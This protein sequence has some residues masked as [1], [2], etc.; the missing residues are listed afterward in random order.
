[1]RYEVNLCSHICQSYNKV[2]V[3]KL[4]KSHSWYCLWLAMK[5][6]WPSLVGRIQKLSV[7][8]LAL[9]PG[10]CFS[11][12]GLQHVVVV[13]S[14]TQY[15]HK[16]KKMIVYRCYHCRY[17]HIFW[18]YEERCA[19]PDTVSG[20]DTKFIFFYREVSECDLTLQIHLPIHLRGRRKWDPTR[21]RV[22]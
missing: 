7:P 3:S 20:S 19:D 22:F 21:R 16:L 8:H 12:H 14:S 2:S 10:F 15:K 11:M 18:E 1:M 4:S 17:W 9:G 6:I 13:T 5:A